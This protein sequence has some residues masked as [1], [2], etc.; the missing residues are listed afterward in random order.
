[1]KTM[2]FILTQSIIFLGDI[3]VLCSLEM[4]KGVLVELKG[5]G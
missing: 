3:F 2:A 1:M 4:E 5:R